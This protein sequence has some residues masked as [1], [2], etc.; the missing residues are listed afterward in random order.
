MKSL[1][2]GLCLAALAGC[3][4][5]SGNVGVVRPGFGGP[6]GWGHYGGGWGHTNVAVV[7]N[8]SFG[9]GYYHPGRW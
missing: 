3:Y 8:R 2:L 5:Y 4:S 7:N 6:G 1:L 9:G